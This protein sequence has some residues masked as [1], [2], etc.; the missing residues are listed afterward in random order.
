[1][2]KT[3]KKTGTG[4]DRAY[5]ALIVELR[6]KAFANITVRM[7]QSNQGLPET[8]DKARQDMIKWLTKQDVDIIF[9]SLLELFKSFFVM[10]VPAFSL[11]SDKNI[12]GAMLDLAPDT[13]FVIKL[14]EAVEKKLSELQIQA[15]NDMKGL[16]LYAKN[17]IAVFNIQNAITKGKDI[18]PD[19]HKKILLNIDPIKK[20]IKI[21]KD[22]KEIRKEWIDNIRGVQTQ[23][24]N[25]KKHAI[26]LI[27][28][29]PDDLLMAYFKE[30]VCK[31][32]DK[33]ALQTGYK[34]LSG[35]FKKFINNIIISF[36]GRGKAYFE[37][38]DKPYLKQEL[39]HIIET[40]NVEIKP[41]DI[42]SLLQKYYDT[43]SKG[44]TRQTYYTSNKILRKILKET[45][46][47]NLNLLK[48]DQPV[49]FIMNELYPDIK[50][51]FDKTWASV[52]N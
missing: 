21:T 45:D 6:L 43:K 52:I 15:D 41:K 31:E 49:Q 35:L 47:I 13:S 30:M 5:Y 17:A 26:K 24:G 23:D 9:L 14:S 25:A 48:H 33:Q 34:T 28:A 8:A 51:A 10:A 36:Y 29:L 12:L 44:S 32:I 1:M 40:L 50:N 11:F 39:E 4:I 22:I 7:K 37:G 20:G 27:E 18:L 42:I 16:P 19:F 2:V 3:D 38:N 46:K